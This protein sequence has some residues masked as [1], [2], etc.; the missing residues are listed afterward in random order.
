MILNHAVTSGLKPTDDEWPLRALQYW[1]NAKLPGVDAV[2]E[3]T[4]VAEG[5]PLHIIARVVLLTIFVGMDGKKAAVPIFY[6]VFRKGHCKWKGA[7]LGGPVLEPA[8]VGLGFKPLSSCH[9]LEG[10]G[11]TL[12]RLEQDI[13]N[14]RMTNSFNCLMTTDLVAGT[15]LQVESF[16]PMVGLVD[17]GE[18][19]DEDWDPTGG[20]QAVFGGC[21]DSGPVLLDAD[22]LSLGPEEGAWVP[23]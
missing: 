3:G 21:A 19:S 2:E 12:P 16:P 23:G 6:K 8:P 18:D 5:A 10:L 1:G 9:L 20:G 14:S 13:V 22:G 4:G 17:W 11:L 15:E 7:I